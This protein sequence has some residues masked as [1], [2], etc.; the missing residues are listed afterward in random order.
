MAIEVAQA[1]VTIMPSLQGAQKS[2]T[3]QLAPAAAS[4]SESVGKSSGQKF[5]SSFSGA[6][7]S[8]AKVIAGAVVASVAS[9]AALSKSFLDAAKSTAAYGDNI[10]KMS[11]KMGLSSTA[12]QEWDFIAQHSGTS[13]DSLKS[14]SDESTIYTFLVVCKST[15]RYCMGRAL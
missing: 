6:L 2:I 14:A 12:F 5:S 13:M 4:A 3:E 7:K 8:G 15:K 1:V 11:Q 9:V 10:D